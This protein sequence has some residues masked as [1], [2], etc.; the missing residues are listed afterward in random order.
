[1]YCVN[2]YNCPVVLQDGCECL[3]RL[4][5]L[6]DWIMLEKHLHYETMS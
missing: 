4:F 2:E 1:M 3:L 5:C 6:D